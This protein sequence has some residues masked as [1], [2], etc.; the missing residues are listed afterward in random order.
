M[1]RLNSAFNSL[2]DQGHFDAK[3]NAPEGTHETAEPQ[4]QQPSQTDTALEPPS[5]TIVIEDDA[6]DANSFTSE[7][8]PNEIVVHIDDEDSS[9]QIVIE[10]EPA[11]PNAQPTATPRAPGVLESADVVIEDTFVSSAPDRTDLDE[12]LL[13]DANASVEY[14]RSKLGLT[15]DFDVAVDA[16]AA[17]HEELLAEQSEAP[18]S[19]DSAPA[20]STQSDGA[21]VDQGRVEVPNT[22]QPRRVSTPK[23]ESSDVVT[24][25]ATSVAEENDVA[26]LF[27]QVLGI[28]N[29]IEIAEVETAEVEIEATDGNA[30]NAP[31]EILA[32]ASAGTGQNNLTNRSPVASGNELAVGH[33]TEQAANAPNAATGF[34][35]GASQSNVTPVAAATVG[36]DAQSERKDS[37]REGSEG[38][39]S[40]LPSTAQPTHV[41]STDVKPSFE[42]GSGSDMQIEVDFE[43]NDATSDGESDVGGLNIDM[44][45]TESRDQRSV[46][47]NTSAP[48]GEAIAQS[49]STVKSHQPNQGQ[50]NDLSG[51]DSMQGGGYNPVIE[52]WATIPSD[53]GAGTPTSQPSAGLRHAPTPSGMDEVAR[54]VLASVAAGG[55]NAATSQVN[56]SVTGTISD[57]FRKIGEK[58]GAPTSGASTPPSEQ[59]SPASEAVEAAALGVGGGQDDLSLNGVEPVSVE[60]VSVKPVSIEPVN[61]AQAN[62]APTNSGAIDPGPNNSGPTNPPPSTSIVPS[63][64]QDVVIESGHEAELSEDVASLLG[65][66]PDGMEPALMAATTEG[67]A[68]GDRSSRR[69][70]PKTISEQ[71]ASQNG[72]EET[73]E[74]GVAI[75]PSHYEIKLASRFV[76]TEFG[77]QVQGLAGQVIEPEDPDKCQVLMLVGMEPN[78]QRADIAAGLGLFVSPQRERPTLLIDADPESRVITRGFEKR[79][80]GILEVVGGKSSWQQC[81]SPTSI[82]GLHTMPCGLMLDALDPT[83]GNQGDLIRQAAEQWREKYGLVIVDA[84]I[85]ASSLSRMLSRHADATYICVQLGKSPRELLVDTT[86]FLIRAGAQV[87][88]CITTNPT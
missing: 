25:A 57:T 84:G 73:E 52:P 62:M 17:P 71:I 20:N 29:E 50:E 70:K 1:S 80:S 69:E 63:A 22:I 51:Q 65:V 4:E 24:S 35:H 85:A 48:T 47:L 32:Q 42:V 53:T 18:L 55:A 49:E 60:P 46:G 58:A 9:N 68:D 30:L 54:A 27:E 3:K 41:V 37:E 86:E 7:A 87:K 59:Y 76:N 8:D 44:E 34:G 15:G 28:Q 67:S 45:P 66:Q 10:D 11:T 14:L 6:T 39:G 74:E 72:E 23:S 16:M 38:A 36:S 21:P 79:G 56:E 81:T 78:R 75:P 61:S 43:V 64:E 33:A 12:Q 88:G 19:T 31:V 26:E 82:N 5:E 77:E 2:A 13:E 40:E 83:R